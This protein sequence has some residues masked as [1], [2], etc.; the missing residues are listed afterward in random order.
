MRY[1]K[2]LA[3]SVLLLSSLLAAAKDKKKILLPADI[4]QAQTT[5]DFSR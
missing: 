2:G 1:R 4:L 5:R 3:V